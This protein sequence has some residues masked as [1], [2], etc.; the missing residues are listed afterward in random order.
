MIVFNTSFSE[1]FHLRNNIC[2]RARQVTDI[3]MRRRE[4]H[5]Y[6]RKRTVFER[7]KLNVK[8]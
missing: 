2:S 4:M 5:K 6:R 1:T 7:K 8:L 3:R